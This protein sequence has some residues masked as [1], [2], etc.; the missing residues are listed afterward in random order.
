MRSLDIQSSRLLLFDYGGTLDVPARH[1][2]NVLWE[3]YQYVGLKVEY[4]RFR[5]AYVYAERRLEA[6]G[7]ISTSDVFRNV[8]YKKF[9]LHL[10]FLHV[11]QTEL[12]AGQM[13]DYC[14]TLVRR[15]LTS[16][17]KLL[18]QLSEAG[19]E[20]GVVS[21]FYGNLS[22]VL[23]DYDLLSFFRTVI[24]SAVVGVRKPSSDIWQKVF[25][26]TGFSESQT[27]VIG[28]SFKN[29]I[30]P[31]HFLG[32]Q[33]VWLKGEMWNPGEFDETIPDVVISSL[34]DLQQILL[35]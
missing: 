19:F 25:D 24:D 3:A 28:D 9:L 31:A 13:A 32:C 30:E 11:P 35:P 17:R 21:N 23:E 18:S 15:N 8:L 14:D 29:D 10:D 1:W 5:D 16:S 33:T 26:K 20:L 22:V 34:D 2:S 4:A 12:Y 7:L 27:I 6:D